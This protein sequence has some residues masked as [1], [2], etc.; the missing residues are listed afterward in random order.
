MN[1]KCPLINV[2][3]FV[4]STFPRSRYSKRICLNEFEV[5]EKFGI[6]HLIVYIQL[7]HFLTVL[8]ILAIAF[9]ASLFPFLILH[10]TLEK[11]QN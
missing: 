8:R 10:P 6:E 5:H 3:I 2:F 11:L 7:A 4:F 1:D 9:T